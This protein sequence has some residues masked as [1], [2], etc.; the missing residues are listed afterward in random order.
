MMK[1]IVSYNYSEK[2]WGLC[3]AGEQRR[4]IKDICHRK[5]LEQVLI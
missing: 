2:L 4:C 1:R 3:Y 5:F